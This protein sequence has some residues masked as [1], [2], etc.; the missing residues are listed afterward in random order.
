MPAQSGCCYLPPVPKCLWRLPHSVGWDCLQPQQST[1][2]CGAHT[3]CRL[4]A[5]WQD[6]QFR[7]CLQR[8]ATRCCGGSP[9][10]AKV[11]KALCCTCR[12]DILTTLCSSHVLAKSVM[13][14]ILSRSKLTRG[15]QRHSRNV[16]ATTSRPSL[17][18]G[19]LM[20]TGAA[21]YWLQLIMM[22]VPDTSFAKTM[23]LPCP[24]PFSVS[25]QLKCYQSHEKDLRTH[26][27]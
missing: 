23:R 4:V 1:A 3:A 22:Y 26:L 9:Y 19:T 12:P 18:S 17:V 11:A 7:I 20:V 8:P 13:M 5:V 27:H 2:G 21:S 10:S 16:C 15:C 6:L 25:Q 14:L 24:Q